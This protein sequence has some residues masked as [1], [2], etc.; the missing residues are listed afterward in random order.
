MDSPKLTNH[1]PFVAEPRLLVGREGEELAVIVKTTF[2]KSRQ[3]EALELGPPAWQR[4]VRG[5]DVPWGDPTK[6]S[7]KYPSDLC[8]AKPGTDVMV[9]GRAHAP[10]NKPV[11]WF[12][13]GIR[14][15]A[16]LK[17]VRIYG[18]RVWESGGAGLSAP[19]PIDSLEVRYDYAW[20]GLD[21][22]DP[23]QPLEEA[24]N[25]VGLGVAR[26]P[27][28]LTH[29]PCPSIEDPAAPI[30]GARGKHVP[31]G[32]GA[33]GR[34]WEPRRQFVGTYDARWLEERA[35]LLPL[36][37][38]DRANQC[39][40]PGLT[41]SPSFRGGEEVTLWNLCPKGG[42]VSFCLPKPSLSVEL[43]VAGREPELRRGC[44]D[45]VLIDTLEVPAGTL[46]LVELVWRARFKGP[47]RM[48]DVEIV[49]S[50]EEAA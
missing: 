16:L 7:V 30:H 43:R 37:H 21:L 47:R 36:D 50:T 4:A 19:R 23:A 3:S 26:D 38:D 39:A 17:V 33:I 2:V 49:V 46:A 6:S 25:P 32:L 10:A 48:K 24:R 20:G 35:P 31:A 29:K 11:P 1:T 28:G 44:L 42:S 22:S 9:V 15:G 8:L 27:A 45:T 18:L 41:A 5:A 12:D 34:H 14:A 13:A 40:T